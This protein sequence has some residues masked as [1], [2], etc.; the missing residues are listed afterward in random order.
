FASISIK[1]E[2]P[3]PLN[4]NQILVSRFIQK[5]EGNYTDKM[6]IYLVDAANATETLLF[7]GNLSVFDPQPLCERFKPAMLPLKRDFNSSTGL[8]FVQ[9]VYEGTHMEG[10]EAGSVKYL[11]V[12]ESPPKLNW[13]VQPWGGQGQQAPGMNWTNFENKRI[14]GEVPVE[15]DGSAY[16]EVPS[17]KFVYF[18]LLDQDKKMI[19]SMRSGTIVQPGEV[20]GCIGCHDNRLNVPPPAG[21]MLIALR[22]KPAQMNGWNGK[23]AELFSYVKQVQPVFDKKCVSCHDFDVNDRNKLV[24]AGDNNP[25]FNASYIDLYVKKKISVAG[26]G[27][28]A[29]QQPYTWGSHASLLTKIID[30]EH[31]EVKL[32]QDEKRV[33]YTWLDINAAYYPVYESA[34]P[35]NIAGRCPLGDNE[36]KQLGKLTGIDFWALNDYKRKAGPQISFER[37]ELSPCLDQIRNDK[38]RYDEAVSLIA[39]GGQ[40]LKTTPNGSMVE[41]FVPCEKDQE[42][43]VRYEE[44]MKEENRFLKARAEGKKAY[45]KQ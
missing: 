6:G 41:N 37:P 15:E 4:E 39:L 23:P 22:K 24:L 44:R 20:N 16:F 18:Q 9:N 1:Y 5:P 14:L 10:V 7:E 34:Y 28:A 12:V 21:K 40:R 43:L 33:I 29:I 11:R 8:F 42:R 30:G 27:P 31:H 13:T 17:N 36:L 38:S 3:F 35:N 26:A 19:Q 32:S 25:Y 45:D 2:D